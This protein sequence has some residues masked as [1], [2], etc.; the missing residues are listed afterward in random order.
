MIKQILKGF[1][2][3]SYIHK[4]LKYKHQLD[5]ILER[6]AGVTWPKNN[7]SVCFFNPISNVVT[8]IQS[9]SFQLHV[10]TDTQYK[11]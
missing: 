10:I 9:L 6:K 2:A 3:L 8:V 7:I 4:C 11:H 5:N 1:T